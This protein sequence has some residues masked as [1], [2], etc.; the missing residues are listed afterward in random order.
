V[1]RTR[2][3]RRGIISE[4]FWVMGLPLRFATEVTDDFISDTVSFIDPR[5]DRK[6]RKHVSTNY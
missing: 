5:R 3:R 6:G 4:A 1:A 2:R